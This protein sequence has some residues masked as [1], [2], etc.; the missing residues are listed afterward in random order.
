MTKRGYFIT[1]G[2]PRVIINQVIR[3][4]GAYF[5]ESKNKLIKSNKTQINRQLYVDLI[6]HRGT[7][8]RLEID[9]RNKIWAK[10]KKSPRIPVLLLLQTFGINKKT[11]IQTVL[12]SNLES[13]PNILKNKKD[14]IENLL[15]LINSKSKNIDEVIENRRKLICY[16]FLN[17]RS[18]YLGKVGR[19]QLN[20]KFGLSISTN[21]TTL[22]PYDIL[23]TIDSLI[24]VFKNKKIVMI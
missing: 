11:I 15:N 23:L 12:N 3:K 2:V 16:K 14:L 19:K 4:P 21:Q 22:T 9:K 20:N 7:W 10:M 5:Q 24:Q 17:A 8:L 1:N 13:D 6:S 18:Y